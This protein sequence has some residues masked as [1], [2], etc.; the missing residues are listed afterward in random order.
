MTCEVI[1]DTLFS[2]F[3]ISTA[4]RAIKHFGSWAQLDKTREECAELSVSLKDF[5]KHHDKDHND[6][7]RLAAIDETA[8]ILFT[9]LQSAIILGSSEVAERI[10]FK[11]NRLIKR[12][13]NETL[14]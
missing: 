13:E 1:R 11:V 12:M 6:K 14:P 4:H 5:E 9:A 10:S 3:V 2:P 7:Y 8:D